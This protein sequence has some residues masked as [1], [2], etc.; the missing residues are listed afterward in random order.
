MKEFPQPAEYARGRV[1]ACM[2]YVDVPRH[3][4]ALEKLDNVCAS[5][6]AQFGRVGAGMCPRM[7]VVVGVVT[8]V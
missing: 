2:V 4:Q 6:E 1:G 5:T 8:V 7:V 3:E